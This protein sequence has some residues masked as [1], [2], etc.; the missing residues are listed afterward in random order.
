MS[1]A[2]QSITPVN[3][4]G[5]DTQL[6]FALYSAQLAMGKVYRNYL[7]QLGLTYSQ[8]LVMLLL[9]ENDAVT[10]NALG[11]RLFLDSATLTPLLKRLQAMGLITKQRD[12]HDQRQVVL[13]LTATGHELKTKALSIPNAVMCSTGCSPT[14]AQQLKHD[15]EILRTNLLKNIS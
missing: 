9:W 11:E 4:L 8:Y 2:A 1:K 5:L 14:Q 3:P 6:C 15:L 13:S 10:V 12:S 7:K